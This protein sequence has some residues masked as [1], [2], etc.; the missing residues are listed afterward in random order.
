M[1][2]SEKIFGIGFHKT[3]TASLAEAL[4]ILGFR[5]AHGMVIN[6][7]KGVHIEPPVTNAKVLPYA[8]ARAREVDAACDSPW[9]TLFR[10]LD[11]AFPGAKFILTLRDPRAWVDSMRR[12]FGDRHSDAL[13]WIYGV[14]CVTGNESRCIEVYEAHNRAVREHF[15]V[16]PA[17]LLE[18]DF[19]KGEGWDKL[20][21]FLGRPVPA[22][23]FPHD[24]TWEER[25]RGRASAW[26]QFKAAIRNAFAA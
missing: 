2:A 21:T 8:V 14:P 19:A 10:E 17:G 26:R 4:R 23:P 20:C 7:P 9:P 18:L 24:N 11:A 15:A 22:Q 25:E 12:H 6:G 3:G 13:Q 5:V 16:R 1:A